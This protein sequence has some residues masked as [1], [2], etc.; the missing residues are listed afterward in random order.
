MDGHPKDGEG[1]EASENDEEE[2][3][4]DDDE[5]EGGEEGGEEGARRR[6]TM[7]R[8]MGRRGARRTMPMRP[9]MAR[10]QM[11]RTGAETRPQRVKQH[12]HSSPSVTSCSRHRHQPRGHREL[13]HGLSRDAAAAAEEV[14]EMMFSAS[15]P[16]LAALGPQ[17]KRACGSALALQRARA[18]QEKDWQASRKTPSQGKEKLQSGGLEVC[19]DARGCSV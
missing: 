18:I 2:D 3:E 5:E 8:T 14:N 9:Q 15:Q 12:S 4:G 7:R 19:G 13:L 11:A 17:W 10:P 1:S 16:T 6:T